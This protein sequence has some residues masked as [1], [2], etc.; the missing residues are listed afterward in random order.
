MTDK[1]FD[2]LNDEKSSL[3]LVQVCASDLM[4]VN[5]AKVSF[6]SRADSMGETEVG[7]LNFLMRNRHGSPFEHNMFTFHV[8]C[9][10]FV[11]RE[12]FRHRIGSFNEFSGR[13]KEMKPDFY[14]P[15]ANDVRTQT[16]KPGHYVMEQMDVDV[17][18]TVMEVIGNS[19]RESWGNYQWMLEQGVAKELARDVLPVNIYTEFYWTVNARALMN[20]LSLRNHEH[21][22]REI[23]YFAECVEIL[24][25]IAM[26]VTYAGFIAQDRVAP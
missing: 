26:P 5:A 2:P 14:I 22:L 7:I 1:V 15:N 24:F 25:G 19:A 17:A 23:R 20:F 8:R 11:A 10:I 13:Y 12:W 16:G 9:P 18:T 4:V 3:S 6:G 21:A